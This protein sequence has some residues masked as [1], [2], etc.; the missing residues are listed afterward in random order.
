MRRRITLLVIATTSAIVVAFVVP[1]CLL[2]RQLAEDR[3][4]A[5][6]DQDARS[7]ALLVASLPPG[8]LRQVVGDR[9]ETGA[10][11]TQVLTVGGE[12][13]GDGLPMRGDADVERALDG[14]AFTVVDDD[15]GRVLLPIVAGENRTTVVR[16]SVAPEDLRRGVPEAWAGITGLGV[17]LLLAAVAIAS[18]LGRRISDPL[19]EVAGTA[20]RLREGDLAARAEV[21]GTEETQELAQALNGLAE[22]TTELLAHERAAVGDL[23]HR[24]RTPVTALR[25]DAEAV[26]D[27]ELAARIHEHVTVLQRTIDAVVKDAR[28][29]VR[30]DLSPSCDATDVLRRRLDFWAPLADDQGR[31]LDVRLPDGAV[32]V[33]LDEDDLVDLV[34]VLVDNVFAHTPEGTALA[35]ELAVDLTAGADAVLTVADDGPGFRPSGPGRRVGSSGLGLDIVGRTADAVGGSLTT[36]RSASGGARVEVRLPRG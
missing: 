31:A 21:G 17:V 28:R 13:L 5:A 26:D 4:M 20:H 34:D 8:Q 23:S 18:R 6:A 29:P 32:R 22:R 24:L 11:T 3:A 16:S 30:T 12:E 9:E 25:L 7:V 10:V 35:V 19:L 27:P 2:V 36:G 15:G 14:Q 1:L 33:A